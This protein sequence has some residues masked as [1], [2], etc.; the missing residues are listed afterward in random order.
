MAITLPAN[1]SDGN[2]ITE[3]YFDSFHAGCEDL[4]NR[5]IVPADIQAGT[6]NPM[7]PTAWVSS[8]HIFKPEFYGSPA[9]RVQSVTADT[10]FRS[11]GEDLVRRSFHHPTAASNSKDAVSTVENVGWVVVRDMAV[12][13]KVPST[14]YVTVMAS[15]FA[16]EIGGDADVIT[17]GI[18]DDTALAA[19]FAVF[20]DEDRQPSTHR[21]LYSSGHS[22]NSALVSEMETA[23]WQQ[24]TIFHETSLTAGVHHLS[25][26]VMCRELN[27]ANTDGVGDDKS[28][29][30]AD[31]QAPTW[32]HIM[33]D[34]RNFVVDVQVL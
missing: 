12:T 2:V 32:K 16:M 24:F 19:W 5:Q 15:F 7:T 11:R 29:R 14:S 31:F 18:G 3:A 28:A 20:E 21:R 22:G 10:H 23:S 9:P 33:V 1:P 27:T 25:V 6:G 26:R 13:V 34:S 30:P 17:D 4:I 8:E